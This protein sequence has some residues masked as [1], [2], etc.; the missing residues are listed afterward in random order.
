MIKQQEKIRQE[1][2]TKQK[3]MVK[4]VLEKVKK[5]NEE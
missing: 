2:E 1:I 3:L 5:E 4:Q